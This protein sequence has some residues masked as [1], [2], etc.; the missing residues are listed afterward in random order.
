M[1][2]ENDMIHQNRRNRNSENMQPR[3]IVVALGFFIYLFF[4]SLAFSFVCSSLTSP[5]FASGFLAHI[6]LC[7]VFIDLCEGVFMQLTIHDMSN[8]HIIIG[9]EIVSILD[10]RNYVRIASF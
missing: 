8:H 5:Y 7:A 4:F 3:R 1:H 10:I 2:A 9:G 6:L